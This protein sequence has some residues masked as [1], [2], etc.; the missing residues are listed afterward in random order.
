MPSITLQGRN[1]ADKVSRAVQETYL[2]GVSGI[3]IQDSGKGTY[4]VFYDL[5]QGHSG[6]LKKLDINLKKYGINPDSVT[7]PGPKGLS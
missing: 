4:C 5:E 1:R 3:G 6:S 2:G 7:G